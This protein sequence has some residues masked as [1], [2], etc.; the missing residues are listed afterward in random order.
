MK[1]TLSALGFACLCIMA[2]AGVDIDNYYCTKFGDVT[3]YGQ[4]Y[5]VGGDVPATPTDSLN[6]LLASF[7]G[8]GYS[9]DIY[10]YNQGFNLPPSVKFLA[11]NNYYF[12]ISLFHYFIMF[13]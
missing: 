8:T 13:I 10:S 3:V 12:V 2:A 7:D 9:E 5:A 6:L 4:F 1:A 11:F